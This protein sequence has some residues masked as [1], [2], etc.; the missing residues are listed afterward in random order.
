MKLNLEQLSEQ[1][2]VPGRTIRYYIQRGLLPQ[3][4][5]RGPDTS[6]GEEHIVRLRAIRRLQ[7]AFWPLEAIAGLLGNK[8]E[9]EI[10]ALADGT[11]VPSP[12]GGALSESAP[13]ATLPRA[14]ASI[15]RET[16]LVRR[17]QL[18]SDL[19]LEMPARAGDDTEALV[20]KIRALIARRH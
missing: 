20:E 19:V 6:Y 12:S 3:P 8:S 17:I 15:R 16:T 11:E 1:A 9:R 13:A 10:E 2:Q 5:F 7:D 18:T 14:V 4:H